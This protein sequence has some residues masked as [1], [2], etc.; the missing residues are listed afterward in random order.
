LSRATSRDPAATAGYRVERN[1]KVLKRIVLACALAPGLSVAMASPAFAC[2]DP[3]LS[4]P[5][6][7]CVAISG[8]DAQGGVAAI[9]LEDAQGDLVAI[10][11]ED[12]QATRGGAAISLDGDA[13]T[14]GLGVA[15][16]PEGDAETKGTGLAVN[17]ETITANLLD[18]P[19]RIP[20]RD[21]TS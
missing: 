9:G 1:E 18:T 17:D 3:D 20:Y 5:A 19:I 12:T 11:G 7:G 2:V 21:T 4:A 13:Q 6:Q 16:A 15:I 10:G 14:E 8:K